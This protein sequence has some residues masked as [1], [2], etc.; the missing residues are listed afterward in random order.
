MSNW[1][2][3]FP[4]A[5]NILKHFGNNEASPTSTIINERVPL[6]LGLIVA[7]LKVLKHES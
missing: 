7:L 4:A 5:T 6:P 1:L 2:C 3:V